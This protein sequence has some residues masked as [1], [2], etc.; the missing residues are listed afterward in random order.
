MEVMVDRI[1][2]GKRLILGLGFTV[3]MTP[4]KSVQ[5]SLGV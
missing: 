4:S 3:F 5:D 1:A 2:R